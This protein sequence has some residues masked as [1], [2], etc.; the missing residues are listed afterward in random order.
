[1]E[2]TKIINEP[3]IRN[4]IVHKSGYLREQTPRYLDVYR[5]SEAVVITLFSGFRELRKERSQLNGS[6]GEVTGSDDHPSEDELLRRLA[7]LLDAPTGTPK[8]TAWSSALSG[9]HN[10]AGSR[11]RIREKREKE[12]KEKRSKKDNDSAPVEDIKVCETQVLK[13]EKVPVDYAFETVYL[14]TVMP[15]RDSYASSIWR[16]IKA[17][18]SLV[19]WIT[20]GLLSIV[21]HPAIGLLLSIIW[22]SISRPVISAMPI[23]PHVRDVRLDPTFE[24][25]NN[26]D[27]IDI[28]MFT[29]FGYNAR[30]KVV[31]S[32]T[33]FNKIKVERMSSAL[34]SHL[35]ASFQNYIS[36]NYA[37]DIVNGI[38]TD[39]LVDNTILYTIQAKEATHIRKVM[40]SSSQ[41]AIPLR[42][43]SKLWRLS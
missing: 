27:G 26:H 18:L 33:I 9:K 1:M 40:S 5:F 38:L 32:R 28:D 39:E 6:N 10:K 37:D 34:S 36:H 7:S 35:F 13:P 8:R 21:T 14:Y 4:T 11:R 24:E 42:E 12:E 20:I 25:I 22:W 16:W 30:R 17:W 43:D 15:S 19:V 2:E 29:H 3:E 31:I 41:G 23:N